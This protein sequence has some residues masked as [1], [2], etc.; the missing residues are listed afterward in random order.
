MWSLLRADQT[1]SRL[2]QENWRPTLLHCGPARF[3]EQRLLSYL[4]PLNRGLLGICPS[5]FEWQGR[6]PPLDDQH[7]IGLSIP[8]LSVPEHLSPLQNSQR[9][10][11]QSSSRLGPQQARLRSENRT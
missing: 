2:P 3:L 11:S 1:F 8:H 5:P 6:E 10:E 9:S 4:C 7:P